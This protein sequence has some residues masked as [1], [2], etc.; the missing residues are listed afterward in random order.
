MKALDPIIPRSEML[1]CSIP[2][3][4]ID[5]HK[6]ATFD[7]TSAQIAAYGQSQT[8]PS[9][10]YFPEGWNGH[11]YWLGS[12]PYPNSTGVFE[13]P[14]IYYGDPDNE[15]NPPRIFTPIS[16]TINGDYSVVNNPVVKVPNNTAINSDPDLWY[17]S[18]NDLM[19]LIS[20]DNKDNYAVYSQKSA[21]GQAWTPRGATPLWRCSIG[22]LTGKPE[23]LSPAILKIGSKIRIY[24]LSGS[25]TI[26]NLDYKLNRGLCWGLWVMEGTS[27]ENG[28]DFSFVKKAAILGKRGIEPWHMDIFEDSRTGYFYM[29]CSA[30]NNLTNTTD[31]YLAE[32]T[33]GWNF[34]LFGRPLLSGGYKHYRPTAV[35]TETNKL[36]VY[37]SVT[38]APTTAASYPNGNSDIPIDGRAI[39]VASKD[40]DEILAELKADK[41]LGYTL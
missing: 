16:G 35:L 30:K 13:N 3:P 10:V 36:V 18:V 17:D 8:H 34:N 29:I 41:V 28:G 12:T 4:T 20:R 22:D 23:F 15:G 25:A 9:I 5:A 11:K 2:V 33:D 38:N 32:S 31:V 26:Y 19:W 21:N 14:C 7:F 1:F 27:L 39:G 6:G 37:W 40:F 24:S